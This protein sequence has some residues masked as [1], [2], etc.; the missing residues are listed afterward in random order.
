MKC[1]FIKIFLF[2]K[3]GSYKLFDINKFYKSIKIWN[4]QKV[5]KNILISKKAKIIKNYFNIDLI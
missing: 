1:F 2:K 4:C 3:N 5:P